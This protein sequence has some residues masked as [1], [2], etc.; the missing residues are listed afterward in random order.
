MYGHKG[1]SKEGRKYPT[2]ENVMQKFYEMYPDATLDSDPD[3]GEIPRV[4]R[5]VF[6]RWM[7][8]AGYKFGR[9]SGIRAVAVA[10]QKASLDLIHYLRQIRN[11]RLAGWK[12]FYQDETWV[13]KNHQ[14]N[15]MWHRGASGEEYYL[16]EGGMELPSGEGER[17][18]IS[19]IV[20]EEGLL[21]GADLVFIGQK[22][23]ADY[24][25]EMNGEHFEEYIEKTVL[26]VMPD[27]SLLVI[28]RASYHMRFTDESKNPSSG[29]W[30]KADII[31]WLI[32]AG[33]KDQDLESLTIPELVQVSKP[34]RKPSEYR[35]D[36]ILRSDPNKKVEV[37]RLPTK[38]C[39]LNPIELIWAFVK[40]WVANK[41]TVSLP[42]KEMQLLVHKAFD[43]VS[44]EL[45]K[46][47]VE[48]CQGVEDKYYTHQQLLDSEVRPMLLQ[49]NSDSEGS[50]ESDSEPEL[51]P[52]AET[53]IEETGELSLQY[54]GIVEDREEEMSKLDAVMRQSADIW[55]L[56]SAKAKAKGCICSDGC[57]ATCGCKKGME[58]GCTRFCKC[59]GDCLGHAA[60]KQQDKEET[61]CGCKGKCNTKA[62]RCYKEGSACTTQCK[63]CIGGK[64]A[65]MNSATTVGTSMKTEPETLDKEAPTSPKKRAGNHGDGHHSAVKKGRTSTEEAP[66]CFV[67]GATSQQQAS[68]AEDLRLDQP[69]IIRNVGKTPITWEDIVAE[70]ADEEE[71]D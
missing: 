45:C 57:T 21:G 54:V 65:C 5:G 15:N 62:C 18:I 33:E 4:R 49:E 46:K 38:H 51:D 29:G 50:G 63:N 44:T 22:K 71:T 67:V 28:D 24:H 60:R 39:E 31:R 23:A 10:R 32:E 70:V 27:K 25:S 16:Y 12:I 2:V 34:Y 56:S 1:G 14:K 64:G 47:C 66:L 42:L 43:E 6:R 3:A 13:N 7:L 69:L 58:I 37:L 36:K 8:M 55:G 41:N 11:Y 68:T 19:H 59:K 40:N 35:V 20:S 48:H 26:P 30:R 52:E 61:K 53:R 17:L 9:V